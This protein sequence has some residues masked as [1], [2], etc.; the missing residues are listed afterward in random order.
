MMLLLLTFYYLILK[1]IN[2]VVLIPTL[3]LLDLKLLTQ[4][5]EIGILDN[6]GFVKIDYGLLFFFYI[7]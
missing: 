2:Q 4:K 7:R 1:K 3:C 6:Q 5:G